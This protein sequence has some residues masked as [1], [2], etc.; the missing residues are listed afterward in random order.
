M[1]YQYFYAKLIQRRYSDS[2][3]VCPER[4]PTPCVMERGIKEETGGIHE[5]TS[6]KQ[7]CDI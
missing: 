2:P 5:L 1:L 3:H 6:K 7:K 4:V